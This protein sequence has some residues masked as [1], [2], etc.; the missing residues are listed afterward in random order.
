[1]R[2]EMTGTEM[3]KITVILL[4]KRIVSILLVLCFVL[5]LSKCTQETE[6]QGKLTA[7]DSYLYG[8]TLAKQGWDDVANAKLDGGVV[9]LAVFTVFF[10]P[11]FCLCLNEQWGAIINFLGALVSG[12]VLFCWVFLFSTSPQIGGIVAVICW[13]SLLCISILTMQD[14]WRHRERHGVS[15]G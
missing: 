14:V 3:T 5:P 1:M 11:A 10:L 12:Y 2:S 4:I 6:H 13:M 8:F 7:S 9:L 15:V